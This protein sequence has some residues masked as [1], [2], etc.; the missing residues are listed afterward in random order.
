MRVKNKIMS[1]LSCFYRLRSG[2]IF[3]QTIP[4]TFSVLFIFD[5]CSIICQMVKVSNGTIVQLAFIETVF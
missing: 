5:E 3:L 4:Q 1:G 2:E